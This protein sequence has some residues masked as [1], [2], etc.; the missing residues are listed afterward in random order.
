MG[1][2][3]LLLADYRLLYTLFFV[4]ELRTIIF[5]VYGFVIFCS[6]GLLLPYLFR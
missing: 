1:D 3:C 2:I 5:I 4:K 6:A